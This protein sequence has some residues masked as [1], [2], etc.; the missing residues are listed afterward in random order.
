MSKAT[1]GLSQHQQQQLRLNMRQMLLGR[2][3]EMSTPEFEEEI[4]RAME[5]NPALTTAEAT[6]EDERENAVETGDDADDDFEDA[7]PVAR[8]VRGAAADFQR[9]AA[10]TNEAES[11]EQ[12][13][14]DMHLSELEKV[15]AHYIIG[16]LDSSGYLTRSAAAIA[17][18]MAVTAGIDV[19]RPM[20]ERM[21]NLVKTLDPAGIGAENLRECLLIQLR[22]MPQTEIVKIAERI[23]A[24]YYKLFVNNRLEEIEPLL[25]TNAEKFTAAVKLIRSLNPKPGAA[26]F[27]RENDE[28][29]SHISPDFIVE[30][31]D[32]ER[33]VVYLAGQIPELVVA[34][35]FREDENK[36]LTHKAAE[37]IKERRDGA[38][39]FIEAVRRRG[40]TLLAVMRAI[41]KL[42]PEYFHTFELQDLRPMVIRDIEA[43]TGIDKSA[44]SRATSGKYMLTPDGLVALKSLFGESVSSVAEIAPREV[45]SALRDIVAEEDKRQPLNDDEIVEALQRRGITVARRTVA[46]YREKCGIPIARLRR[47]SLNNE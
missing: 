30:L 41:I 47:Q 2:L 7:I 36:H 37:F 20:V 39:E 32:K 5:E 38:E 15:T 34:P 11:V 1:Q 24:Q 26:L 3:L 13:L 12:Q 25:M 18:D 14:A 21:I 4:V 22:R 43:L 44:V 46:K 31:D 45:E 40:S 29:I 17:D 27:D 23:L 19:G 28:R 42:Q 16:N 6:G 33:P 8:H 9:T 35:T 10:Q